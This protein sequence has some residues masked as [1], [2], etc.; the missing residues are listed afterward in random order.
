MLYR[1]S[2]TCVRYHWTPAC[3]CTIQLAGWQ[4][5]YTPLSP[6]NLTVLWIQSRPLRNPSPTV[7]RRI[8]AL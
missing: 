7:P 1:H 5:I 2:G 6:S 4:A 3:D 8:P